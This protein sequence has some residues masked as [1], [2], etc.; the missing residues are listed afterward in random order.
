MRVTY[1]P[2][3]MEQIRGHRKVFGA[4][5]VVTI[6]VNGE[7]VKRVD[8]KTYQTI[9]EPQQFVMV[10]DSKMNIVPRYGFVP[11]PEII[12]VAEWRV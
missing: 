5:R 3:L 7:F 9:D 12:D 4:Q 1:T 8:H 10:D 11:N 6:R 2:P